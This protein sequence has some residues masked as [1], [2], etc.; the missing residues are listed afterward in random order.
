MTNKIVPVSTLEGCVVTSWQG[1]EMALA[2]DEDRLPIRWEDPS[3]PFLQFIWLDLQLDTGQVLRLISQMDHGTGHHGFY[4]EEIAELPELR[5][6]DDPSSVFRDR[7]LTELP[8]G[9][10]EIVGLLMDGPSATVEMRL[11]LSGAELR[12]VAA[13]VYEEHDGSVRIVEHDES[14]LIQLDG[15]RPSRPA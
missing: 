8:L 11:A 10:V 4:L 13:E 15:K 6:S 5:V 1:R 14:I 7:A 12:L 9:E 2:G 3:T